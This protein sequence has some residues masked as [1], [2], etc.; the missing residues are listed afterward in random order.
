MD[1]DIT[2]VEIKIEGQV[3]PLKNVMAVFMVDSRPQRIMK[4]SQLRR[5]K[6]IFIQ[7]K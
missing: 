5:V 6:M 4:V 7:K 3:L 2:G 1:L